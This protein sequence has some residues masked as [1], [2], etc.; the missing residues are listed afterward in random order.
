MYICSLIEDAFFHL[1]RFSHFL[2]SLC[3]GVL[4]PAI[5]RIFQSTTPYTPLITQPPSRERSTSKSPPDPPTALASFPLFPLSPTAQADHVFVAYQGGWSSA[6]AGRD[7]LSEPP[8]VI[9]H[10][11]AIT[12]SSPGRQCEVLCVQ[13][14][15]LP[16][17]SARTP[18]RHPAELAPSPRR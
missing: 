10:L 1:S 5:L 17:P 7:H 3:P 16:H 14:P 8:R 9:H 13:P 12:E 18:S 15:S 2:S 11:A 6:F 4:D